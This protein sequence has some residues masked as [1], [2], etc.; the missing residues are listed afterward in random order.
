MF[1]RS[2]DAASRNMTFFI[3]VTS[4]PRISFREMGDR[5]ERRNIWQTKQVP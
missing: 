3:Q 5:L 1:T 2:R 4:T